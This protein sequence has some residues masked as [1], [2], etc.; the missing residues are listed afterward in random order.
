[1]VK[2]RALKKFFD[3]RGRKKNSGLRKSHNEVNLH[4]IYKV[5][6]DDEIKGA[7]IVCDM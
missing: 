3:V 7:R 5:D 1:V 4:Y 2:N 6:S